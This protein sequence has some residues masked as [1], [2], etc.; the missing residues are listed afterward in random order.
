M[1]RWIQARVPTLPTP[2]TLCAVSTHSNSSNGWWTTRNERRYSATTECMY[3][4]SSSRS[5]TS[6]TRSPIGMISGGSA[7]MRSSPS[8]S[9]VRFA[10]TR[11][12]SRVR[13]FAR[14]CST[15]AASFLPR[16]FSLTSARTN[17][18]TWLTSTESYHASSVRIPA[19]CRITMRYSATHATTI[20]R[21]SAGS[22]PR[23]RPRTS[24]LAASR[25]TSH[26]HG[27]G[28]V[29]SKS[30][31]SKSSCRSG[32]AKTPKF[33]RCA[34]PQSWVWTPETGVVER[35][36]AMISAPPR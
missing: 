23:S 28:S 4:T 1:K 6:A 2:T 26:S 15:S 17:S 29:S 9:S 16:R 32:E 7:T 27:P 18:I 30:L 34:S 11:A 31:M 24:K 14:S 13:A 12:W 22:N 33:D 10:K 20:A 35:S 5:A 25:F 19:V 21:R 36:D 3:A 8:I